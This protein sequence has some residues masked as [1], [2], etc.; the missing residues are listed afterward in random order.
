MLVLWRHKLKKCH[1]PTM[2]LHVAQPLASHQNV[3]KIICHCE[4]SNWK[5]VGTTRH[6][7]PLH[8]FLV[9]SF[10]CESLCL[11]PTFSLEILYLVVLGQL[12]IS[13]PRQDHQPPT[14]SNLAANTTW[15]PAQTTLAAAY[16][17]WSS[18]HVRSPDTSAPTTV[19][20][21]SGKLAAEK[22]ML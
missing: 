8:H 11:C 10:F 18:A 5:P 14:P 13:R 4:G 12:T 7:L 9:V 3:A 17:M 2:I 15:L 20:S 16:A 22:S 19:W 6:Y 1:K 21:D